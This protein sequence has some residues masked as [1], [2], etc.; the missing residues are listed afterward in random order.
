MY[1]GILILFIQTFLNYYS[2]L[3]EYWKKKNTLINYFLFH[4]FFTI[5]TE[6]YSKYWKNVS[7]FSNV[8]PHILQFE[9]MD[10]F[11]KDRWNDISKMSSFHKLTQ[12]AD[13]SKA[14]KN[15]FYSYIIKKYK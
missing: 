14:S 1:F 12:K 11:N 6:K 4:I 7:K 8:P 15:S 10:D 3:F 13:F 5:A 9:I 2:L